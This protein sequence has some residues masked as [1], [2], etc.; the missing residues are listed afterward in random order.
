[1]RLQRSASLAVLVFGC[2]R[3]GFSTDNPWWAWKRYRAALSKQCPQ[4]RLELLPFGD[5]P[6]V[7]DE[8]GSRLSV[9]ERR[10]IEHAVK[11]RCSGVGFGA[12][13]GNEAF[14]RVMIQR[15][16]LDEFTT[17]VCQLPESCT[18]QSECTQDQ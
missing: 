10:L 5:L 4:K 12:S 9:S 3:S 6:D 14:L 11:D 18:A 17:F 15:H 2:A 16:R 7:I 8:F 13:C 1:M